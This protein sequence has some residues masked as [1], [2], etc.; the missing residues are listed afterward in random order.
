MAD[1]RSTSGT[2]KRFKSIYIEITNQCDR[3]CA[4]CPGTDR[5]PTQ[6]DGCLF[7]L[8]VDQ[9]APFA[10]QIYPHV[11]GE[12][13]THPDFA[14][15]VTYCEAVGVPMAVTTNGTHIHG[16]AGQALMNP[17]VA[18]VNFSLHGLDPMIEDD[19]H[20]F[21]S[22]LDFI[23]QAL[24]LRPELYLN[25]RLWNLD[26]RDDPVARETN[27]LFLTQTEER[28]GL[29]PGSAGAPNTRK[30]RRLTGRLY[31]HSDTVFEWPGEGAHLGGKA[32]SSRKADTGEHD[33]SGDSAYR[34]TC[35]AMDTHCAILAD[36]TVVPCCLDRNG[37]IALG[38]I[39]DHSLR[40]ILESPRAKAI[41]EGFAR[42]ELVEMQCRHCGYRQRFDKK[43]KARSPTNRT[44]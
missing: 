36:G 17:I 12:P 21:G 9:A 13:L 1:T 44:D 6:M 25:L 30:S 14:S 7:R 22:I 5:Q 8:S 27:A 15:F 37:V 34:G 18:Q 16:P 29:T 24:T 10:E 32:S 31:L 41:K 19:R 11:L 40:D 33:L 43:I 20:I 35:R 3:A 38:N 39:R 26:K 28:F 23:G 42:G 4:F 2:T